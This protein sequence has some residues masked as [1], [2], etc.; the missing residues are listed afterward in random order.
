MSGPAAARL[1][2]RGEDYVLRAL[3]RRGAELLDRNWRCTFGE[4]DLVAATATH[5]RFIEVKTRS[6]MTFQE[7]HEAVTPAK[8][9]RIV[10]SAQ[11]WLLSHPEEQR[12]CTF[13]VAEVL[14]TGEGFKM[15]YW[16][17]AFD[18]QDDG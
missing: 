9:R 17:D 1:G 18:A 3:E 13:D 8:R 5:V 11:C 15:R 14:V 2:R 16:A 4:L 6:S 12:P 7:P 10:R